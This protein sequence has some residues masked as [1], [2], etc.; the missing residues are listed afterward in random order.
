MAKNTPKKVPSHVFTRDLELESEYGVTDIKLYG[1]WEGDSTLHILG[2]VF[3]EKIKEQ[4]QLVCSVYDK[5]GDVIKSREN[6][7]YGGSGWVTSRIKPG[8]FFS[9]F[10]FEFTLYDVK[11]AQAKEIRIVLSD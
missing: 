2:Q 5:D 1:Y 11:P 9:G 3:A 6:S 10:P 4:F 8:A 7:S